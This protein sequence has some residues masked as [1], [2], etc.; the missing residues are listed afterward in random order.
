MNPHTP[1][2]AAATLGAL[3]Q[4]AQSAGL[5]RL[6][7]QML[8]LHSAGRPTQDRAW[9]LAH[10]DEYASPAIAENFAHFCQRRLQGEP[11]AYLTGHKAFYGLD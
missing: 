1:S 9:L 6:E 10:T 4:E 3:L 7:A 5:P 2:P 11:I 8:L